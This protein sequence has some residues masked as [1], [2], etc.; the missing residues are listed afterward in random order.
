MPGMGLIAPRTVSGSLVAGRD[1]AGR[2]FVRHGRDYA[3]AAAPGEAGPTSRR[4]YYSAG[5]ADGF[6]RGVSRRAKAGRS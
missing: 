5:T 1:G 4:R 2:M 3:P 6:G